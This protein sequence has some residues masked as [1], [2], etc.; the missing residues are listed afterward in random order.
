MNFHEAY[1]R[2]D[3]EKLEKKAKRHVR[4]TGHIVTVAL[5]SH[6][7]IIVEDESND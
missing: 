1:G 5:Q 6:K 7:M 2:N 3:A 4:T